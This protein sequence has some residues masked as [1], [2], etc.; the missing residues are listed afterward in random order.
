MYIAIQLISG[1][2][3]LG[4]GTARESKDCM[5]ESLLTQRKREKVNFQQRYL[6][7]K[8]RIVILGAEDTELD[9]EIF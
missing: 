7:F 2:E 8:N 9:I 5:S 3:I 6:F 1:D 4:E